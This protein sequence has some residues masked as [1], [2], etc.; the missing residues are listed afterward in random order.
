MDE[1]ILAPGR[2]GGHLTPNMRTYMCVDMC[3]ANWQRKSSVANAVV[4]Y[5]CTDMY[6]TDVYMQGYV[7]T[8]VEVQLLT[9]AG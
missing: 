4:V 9:C 7:L 2:G 8:P 6:A 3:Q 1:D 5:K